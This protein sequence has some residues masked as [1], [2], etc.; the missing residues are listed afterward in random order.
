VDLVEAAVE[1]GAA[2]QLGVGADGLDPAGVHQDDAV[3]A[4]EGAE[5]V[6]DQ[7]GG[8]AAGELLDG[9]ADQASSW[10]STALVASSR[11]R[12]AGSR[13]MARARAIRWRWP[14]E[15]FSPRSRTMV[16]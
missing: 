16:S 8:P 4:L 7:E 14:P 11:I 9:L 15:R 1:G 5:A 2:A 3:G 13:S 6:G 10:M 12:I